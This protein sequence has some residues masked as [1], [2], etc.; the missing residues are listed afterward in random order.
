MAAGLTSS[1]REQLIA[2]ASLAVSLWLKVADT[3]S[4][5]DFAIWMAT[6][7]AHIREGLHLRNNE[8]I[9]NGIN[10]ANLTLAALKRPAAGR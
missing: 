5:S 9:L 4:A 3:G 10:L 2:Q 8:I 7:L 6:S 1:E